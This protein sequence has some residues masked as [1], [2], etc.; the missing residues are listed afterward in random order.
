[1][2]VANENL[3][4]IYVN[5]SWMSVDEKPETRLDQEEEGTKL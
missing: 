1:M 3:G 4:K 2:I 5:N